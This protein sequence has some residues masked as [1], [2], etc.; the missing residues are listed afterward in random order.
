MACKNYAYLQS[1]LTK[2]TA[3]IFRE[4][5]QVNPRGGEVTE[6]KVLNFAECLECAI[7][8]TRQYGLILMNSLGVSQNPRFRDTLAL[9]STLTRYR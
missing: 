2:L 3:D 9:N 6:V 1:H 7:L 8:Y 5:V 4:E